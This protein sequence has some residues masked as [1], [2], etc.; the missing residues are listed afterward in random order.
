MGE[1]RGKGEMTSHRSASARDLIQNR[2][3]KN[4]KEK[5]TKERRVGTW[6]CGKGGLEKQRVYEKSDPLLE[7]VPEI[8]RNHP[9]KVSSDIKGLTKDN[10]Q[11]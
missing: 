1:K 11:K 4:K 9:E 3:I 5:K 7:N 6:G 10:M 8:F 2:I